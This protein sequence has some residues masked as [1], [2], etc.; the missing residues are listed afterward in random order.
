[1]WALERCKE[2]CKGWSP[3]LIAPGRNA[4]AVWPI[5]SDMLHCQFC[6]WIFL[7]LLNF[8]RMCGEYILL[9]SCLQLSSGGNKQ[10]KHRKLNREQ[11]G[12]GVMIY[13]CGINEPLQLD[14][15]LRLTFV[16]CWSPGCWTLGCWL[17]YCW[18]TTFYFPPPSTTGAKVQQPCQSFNRDHRF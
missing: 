5:L 6:C 1:M 14:A 9:Q 18:I 17:M 10:H 15:V 4:F 7:L 16:S 11:E 12:D 2:R 3:A 8:L 13:L